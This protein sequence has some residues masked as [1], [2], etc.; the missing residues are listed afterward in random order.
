MSWYDPDD[1]LVV[2]EE[3]AREAALRRE[4]DEGIAKFER[5]A[6]EEQARD[7]TPF[8]EAAREHWTLAVE[9]TRQELDQ[10]ERS[11]QD[12]ALTFDQATHCWDSEG[13]VL[14]L[15]RALDEERVRTMV[16]RAASHVQRS[17]DDL[18]AAYDA[19][20]QA[21]AS[22]ATRLIE[23]VY[24]LADV[25][26]VC[27]LWGVDAIRYYGDDPEQLYDRGIPSAKVLED[28]LTRLD[29][30][31]IAVDAIVDAQVSAQQAVAE[32]VSREAERTVVA[33]AQPIVHATKLTRL[34]QPKIHGEF[35][36]S[37]TVGVQV[38]IYETGYESEL[39]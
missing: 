27:G 17:D 28:A 10:I 18:E 7:R 3:R 33:E 2:A 25:E 26:V 37:S 8:I 9:R 29:A 30:G 32:P 35:V 12:R 22:E 16:E 5:L 15:P 23:E 36:R 38:P 19:V 31:K 24:P 1:A 11:G 20:T 4:E 39:E 21:L 13:A 34:Q 14:V 6:R